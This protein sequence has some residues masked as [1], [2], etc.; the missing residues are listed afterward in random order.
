MLNRVWASI[1]AVSII[2]LVYSPLLLA[3]I[4]NFFQPSIDLGPDSDAT[5]YSEIEIYSFII[6]PEEFEEKE[7]PSEEE[8]VQPAPKKKITTQKQKKIATKKKSKKTPILTTKITKAAQKSFEKVQK[9]E[10]KSSSKKKIEKKTP[11]R[12]KRS[13][14]SC[15]PRP[16]RSIQSIGKREY[17]IKKNR[18]EYYTNSVPNAKKLAKAYW[19]E[20]KYGKGI[21]LTSIPCRSPLRNL[22]IKPR[23]IIL[24]VNGK[25]INNNA[26]LLYAYGQ[27][28]TNKKIDI[29]LKRKASR[30]TLRYEIVKS[31]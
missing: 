1:Q 4:P 2:A 8:E 31:L 29:L 25:K 12:K 19:Y 6:D 30:F 21:M 23:D 11:K 22:G 5:E 3:F 18:F 16:Q 24:A 15:K 9:V 17:A 28:K 14:S 10:E 20:G 7:T 27:L 26:D 13:R